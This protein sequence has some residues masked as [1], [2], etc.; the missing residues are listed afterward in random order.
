MALIDSGR[1][2]PRVQKAEKQKA[3]RAEKTEFLLRLSN[4]RELPPLLLEAIGVGLTIWKLA[5]KAGKLPTIAYAGF[6]VGTAGTES[7]ISS[8]L[9]WLYANGYLSYIAETILEVTLYAGLVLSC[10]MFLA[11]I[12]IEGKK[13]L[14][15]LSNKNNSTRRLPT[16]KKRGFFRRKAASS[17]NEKVPETKKKISK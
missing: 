17:K 8:Y 9:R 5:V 3:D 11:K 4:D 16:I 12:A 15:E 13:K 7:V 6:F 1:N 2:K 10:L 14:Y